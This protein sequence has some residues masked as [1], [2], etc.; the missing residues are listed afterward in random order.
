MPWHLSTKQSKEKSMYILTPI[1][2]LCA[3]SQWLCPTNELRILEII[4]PGPAWTLD[5]IKIFVENDWAC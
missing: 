5:N 1:N 4:M 2:L 3:S